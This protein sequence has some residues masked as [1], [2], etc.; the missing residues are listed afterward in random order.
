M[1]GTVVNTGVMIAKTINYVRANLGLEEMKHKHLLHQVNNPDINPAEYFYGT[2]YFT[3]E[4]TKLFEEYY[5]E[6]CIIGVELYDGMKELLCDLSGNCTLTIATNAHTDFANRILDHLGVHSHFDLI[7]GADKVKNSKPH[8][9]MI[10]TTL[11]NFSYDKKHSILVGDSPKDKLAAKS[12]GIKHLM[13][14]WGFTEH[15]ADEE[16]IKDIG[17][18]KSVLKKF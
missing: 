8:P 2:E 15:D 4:Q 7:I 10:E 13:V 11:Q 12:A 18:L 1:D 16:V 17:T 3:D 14:D 9:E 5:H 6:N